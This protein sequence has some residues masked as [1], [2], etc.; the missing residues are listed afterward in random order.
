MSHLIVTSIRLVSRRSV[1]IRTESPPKVSLH[2]VSERANAISAFHR[3]T[4]QFS[5]SLCLSLWSRPERRETERVFIPVTRRPWPLETGG[6]VLRVRIEGCATRQPMAT[7]QQGPIVRAAPHERWA[8]LMNRLG[9]NQD[10][11]PCLGQ[12]KTPL[13]ISCTVRRSR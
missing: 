5:G 3:L 8:G 6:G 1:A 2:I 4:A 11:R 12:H 7:A 9:G 13:R 10:M